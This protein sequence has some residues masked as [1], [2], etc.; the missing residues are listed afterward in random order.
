MFAA[1]A[2]ETSGSDPGETGHLQPVCGQEGA[3][4]ADDYR[5]E[6]LQDGEQ[7][8]LGAG[9]TADQ[10]STGFLFRWQMLSRNWRISTG[11]SQ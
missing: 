8:E 4:Q 6:A 10:T 2:S 5:D 9:S 1:G 11:S 3:G 7:G